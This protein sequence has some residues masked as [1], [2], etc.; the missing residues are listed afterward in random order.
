MLDAE[1]ISSQVFDSWFSV[2]LLLVQC[3]TVVSSVM[4]GLKF[5]FLFKENRMTISDTDVNKSRLT[6]LF[7]VIT[8]SI[9][10]HSLV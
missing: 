10:L 6:S 4:S 9:L 2:P 8:F 1:K 3:A 5:I 7:K